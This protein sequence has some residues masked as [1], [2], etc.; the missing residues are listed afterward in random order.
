MTRRPVAVAA[1]VL[2]LVGGVAAAAVR[3]SA[4]EPL[5]VTLTV[6]HSRFTPATVDVARGTTVRFLV[7]NVDPIDHE[8]I[9][10]DQEVQDRHELGTEGHHGARPGE[11]SVGAEETAS[12]TITFRRPGV[13]LFGC[14]LPGHWAY[15]MRGVV[16]VS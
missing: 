5:V 4:S 6:R 13:V 16:R 7:R 1:V 8:L 11:V 3:R 15:G 10:G 9:V 2:L 12:T 14:H